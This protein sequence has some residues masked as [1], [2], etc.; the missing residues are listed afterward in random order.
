M[1]IPRFS[2]L[3]GCIKNLQPRAFPQ[4]DDEGGGKSGY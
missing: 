2:H 3:P 4:T 1:Q